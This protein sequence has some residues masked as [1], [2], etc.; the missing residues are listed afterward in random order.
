MVAVHIRR[1]KALFPC[2][3]AHGNDIL[4]KAKKG[5]HYSRSND[6][7]GK[8]N[9]PVP[10]RKKILNQKK[11]SKAQKKKPQFSFR[12]FGINRRKTRKN[13]QKK[14]AKKGEFE[15]RKLDGL[16]FPLNNFKE[17]KE[18]GRCQDNGNQAYINRI[19]C[20]PHYWG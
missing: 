14:D 17:E 16:A 10:I 11:E 5:K 19:Y 7:K 18:K 9:H 4:K 20:P 3:G 6:S 2:R 8:N 15:T 12:V 13:S 1:R